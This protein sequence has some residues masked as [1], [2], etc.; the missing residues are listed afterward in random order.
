MII[1]VDIGY[2]STKTS[3]G[4]IFRSQYSVGDSISECTRIE[5]DGVS[6]GIGVGNGTLDANKINS[7]LNRVCLFSALAMSSPAD[8]FQL[9]TG[10]PVGQY[11]QR[12]DEFQSAIEK[13]S[14]ARVYYNGTK[15]NICIDR[16][17]IYPQGVGALVTQRITGNAIVLDIGSRTTDIALFEMDGSTRRMV[18]R[19][20][21]F[22]GAFQLYSAAVS[23][24]NRIYNLDLQPDCGEALVRD[25]LYVYGEQKSKAFLNS[26]CMDL[27]DPICREM[28]LTFHAS[29][30][31][32][33][34]CG[35]GAHIFGRYIKNRYGRVSMIENPQFANANGFRKVGEKMW[36]LG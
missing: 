36:L 14:S 27:L 23:A 8:H 17:K 5:I 25:D 4:T 20:T 3:E 30:T 11:E 26:L 34:L 13:A 32:I 12:K 10:L 22:V 15:R 28:D 29:T 31:P 19:S 2:S 16:V 6:Y 33:Y 35:G 7:D 9:V 18:A 1:G 21:V 24:A